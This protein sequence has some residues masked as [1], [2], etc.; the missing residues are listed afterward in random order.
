MCPSVEGMGASRVI[1]TQH[2]VHSTQYPTNHYQGV[3]FSLLAIA[4]GMDK[5]LWLRPR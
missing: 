3:T 1:S 4:M 2:T 5:H